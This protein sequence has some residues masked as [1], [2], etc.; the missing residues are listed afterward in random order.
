MFIFLCMQLEVLV[1]AC[2]PPTPRLSHSFLSSLNSQ[3]QAKPATLLIPLIFFQELYGARYQTG[4][5]SLIN[6]GALVFY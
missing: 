2:R 5:F 3:L 6:V 4:S 1:P